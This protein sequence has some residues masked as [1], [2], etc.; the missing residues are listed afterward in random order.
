MKQALRKLVDAGPVDIDPRRVDRVRRDLL[1]W[2]E[3]N[4]RDLP[5]R[6]DPTPYRVWVS[7][8]ML[9]QT[10]VGTVL[11]YYDRFLARFP[12]LSSLAS[13]PIEDVLAAWSGLGYYRRARLLH[14]GARHVRD[15]HGGEF[16]RGE[17][18]ALAIPGVGAYTAGAIR[19]IAFG[20]RAPILDGNGKRVLARAFGVAGDVSKSAVASRLWT[21]ARALVAEGRPSAVNQ[22]QMELGALVCTPTSP[23]C[24]QCP[25]ASDCVAR[26]E[27]AVE[28]YPELPRRRAPVDVECVALF[29]TGDDLLLLR[30]RRAGELHEGLW[31]LPG[32]FTGTN[33]DVGGDEDAARALVPFP[34]TVN[35]T[36]GEIRHAVTHRRIRIRVCAA[37]SNDA[38]A[39]DGLVGPDGASFAWFD[40]DEASKLALPAP[41]RRALERWWRAPVAGEAGPRPS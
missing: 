36:L 37:A 25:I 27:N 31:D 13:A 32:G 15:E 10:R 21:L 6:R 20:E 34:L 12:S 14:E 16:P 33:G 40:R 24:D 17:K 28:R 35:E 26:G 41:T 11:G 5:W 39:A 29:V 9:Q 18:E 7:E 2:Y 3:G 22:A 1:S 19:S 23:R 38:A 30:R 8:I 4:A